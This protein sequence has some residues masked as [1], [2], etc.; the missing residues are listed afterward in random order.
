M[1][2]CLR[3]V[4]PTS[5]V[6]RLELSQPCR[7][8]SPPVEV[9][10]NERC[11]A[12]AAQRPASARPPYCP[13]VSVRLSVC[14]EAPLEPS[15]VRQLKAR[16]EIGPQR[17]RVGRA[18][19][20]DDAWAAEEAARVEL[21]DVD[22]DWREQTLDEEPAANLLAMPSEL[23]AGAHSSRPYWCTKR[24]TSPSWLLGTTQI[25]TSFASILSLLTGSSC[26]TNPCIG[27]TTAT[28]T[29]PDSAPP[30]LSLGNEYQCRR[31]RLPVGRVHRCRARTAPLATSRAH[32]QQPAHPHRD[33]RE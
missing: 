6:T 3:L 25:V 5:G 20:N 9:P 31:H 28:G 17:S 12:E 4:P 14:Q 32:E 29:A 10:A 22:R 16:S 30:H 19:E 15:V 21:D 8:T 1:I 18:T 2:A 23:A 27:S 7:I 11:L 24:R 13:S 26:C 33:R